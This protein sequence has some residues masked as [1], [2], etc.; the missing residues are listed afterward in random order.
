M[1]RRSDKSFGAAIVLGFLFLISPA[2]AGAAIIPIA[3]IYVLTS[4]AFLAGCLVAA[5][6]KR[7]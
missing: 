3:A 7:R 6:R 2:L 4:E 5:L 1:A